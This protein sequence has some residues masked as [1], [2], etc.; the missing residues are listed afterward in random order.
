M[1]KRHTPGIP[2][3]RLLAV[4]LAAALGA[5]PA[6]AADLVDQEPAND[7]RSTTPTQ[8][9]RQPSLVVAAGSFELSDSEACA[10]AV[11][12]CDRDWVRLVGLR[13]GDFVAISTAGRPDLSPS[14]PDTLL[15]FF[16]AN[17]TLLAED[18]DFDLPSQLGFR[19]TSDGDYAFAVT[20]TGDLE[21]VGDHAEKGRYEIS[22]A[23][24]PPSGAGATL[25]DK[26]PFNDGT[27]IVTTNTVGRGEGRQVFAGPFTLMSTLACL[28]ETQPCDVDFMRI[29][30][31]FAG[32]RMTITTYP[33]EPTDESPGPDTL[34][35]T[36]DASGMQLDLEQDFGI[37][38]RFDYVVPD[39]GTYFVGI[40]GTL[41]DA[42]EGWHLETGPYAFVIS[43]V[44]APAPGAAGGGVAALLAL[45]SLGAFRRP[46]GRDA[47]R[48]GPH[49]P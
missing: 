13:A 18:E 40:T 16:D 49:K 20:G 41:D 19:V 6:L 39:D 23:I 37:A 15:G 26:E 48:A 45:G 12:T 43:I 2:R 8:I 29:T 11:P 30:G 31:A 35:G 47:R 25:I 17:G 14:E 9:V 38:S 4:G 22:V 21:Y 32:D 5:M 42:F 34:A 28:A 1:S 24:L 46:G 3:K 44:P 7:D 36:F 27:R 33:L 10:E